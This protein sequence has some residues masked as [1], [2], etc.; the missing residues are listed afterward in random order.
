[1]LFFQRFKKKITQRKFVVQSLSC[2]QLSVIPRT[3]ARPAPLSFTI[4][5]SLLQFKSNELVM[6]SKHLTFCHTPSPFAF[7][8]SQ[9]QGLFQ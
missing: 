2:V 4:T 3:A 1:M 6:L 5:W 8:L 7:N 9:H